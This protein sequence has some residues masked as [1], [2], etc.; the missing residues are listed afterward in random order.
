MTATFEGIDYPNPTYSYVYGLITPGQKGYFGNWTKHDNSDLALVYHYG[1]AVK[2]R[3][4]ATFRAI[5]S[6]SEPIPYE[7]RAYRKFESHLRGRLYL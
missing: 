5:R 6:W 1:G 7:K 4:P 3:R 2:V